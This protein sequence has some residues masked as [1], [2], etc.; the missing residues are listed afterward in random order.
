MIF[1]LVPV[2]SRMHCPWFTS[3]RYDRK[4][5]YFHNVGHGCRVKLL[6]L[7]RFYFK[8]IIKLFYQ[9]YGVDGSPLSKR[10]LWDI[11]RFGLIHM[12]YRSRTLRASYTQGQ[13]QD[14]Q[15]SMNASLAMTVRPAPKKRRTLNVWCNLISTYTVYWAYS[16]LLLF[17]YWLHIDLH[18]IMYRIVAYTYSCNVAF[19]VCH[20][21]IS[22]VHILCNTTYA[23]GHLQSLK[24]PIY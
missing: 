16:C 21:Q 18:Y 4:W 20:S 22:S 3:I 10:F 1:F 8:P 7:Y 23:Y 5:Q 2:S 19:I 13:K 9:S 14:R 15:L 11:F 12:S 6:F 24:S 17:R